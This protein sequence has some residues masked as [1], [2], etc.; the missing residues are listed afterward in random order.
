VAVLVGGE[1]LAFGGK[2]ALQA[3]EQFD[4]MPF[5]LELGRRK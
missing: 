1:A 5:Y 3:L 4:A 2:Q